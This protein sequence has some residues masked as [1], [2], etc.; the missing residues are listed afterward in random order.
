M[1]VL[2]AYVCISKRI[3]LQIKPEIIEYPSP[4]FLARSSLD[5]SRRNN[6]NNT[7]KPRKSAHAVTI[8]TSSSINY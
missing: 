5:N 8:L 1:P 7:D 3:P 4:Y 6:Q 2:S